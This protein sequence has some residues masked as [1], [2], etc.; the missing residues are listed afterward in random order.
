MKNNLCTDIGYM[1][2][3]HYGEQLCGDHVE[4]VDKLDEGSC[5]VVLA[6]GLGSGVKANILSILTSK[7]ISTMVA[8]DLPLESAVEIEFSS[9]QTDRYLSIRGRC[10]IVIGSK[11]INSP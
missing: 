11:Y 9:P 2:L 4:V 6:D 1:S 3:T 7:M 5:V 10:L 8:A